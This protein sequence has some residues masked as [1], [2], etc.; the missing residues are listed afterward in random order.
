M[1]VNEYLEEARRALV[2]L[3]ESSSRKALIYL[4]EFLAKQTDS[5]GV[6]T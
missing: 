4:T 3:E 5:L 2:G 6:S 1:V